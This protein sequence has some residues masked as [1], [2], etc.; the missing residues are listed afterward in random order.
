MSLYRKY[1]PQTF[2]EVVG[3]EHIV[4]T[5]QGAIASS[6]IG[7]AYIFAGPRGTGKTSIARIFAKAVNCLKVKDGEPCGQCDVCRQIAEGT[8]LDMIEID[9]ASNR[10]IDD[11]RDLK[12]KIIFS[13]NVGKYKVYIIDEAHMLSRD[14]FNALLKTLEEPPA[15]VIFVLATTESQKIPMTILSRCQRF[16]F[17]R[18]NS[19]EMIEAIKII[20]KAEKIKTTDAIISQIVSLGEGSFRDSLSCLDQ[21][22][23]FSGSGEI[24]DQ[25]LEDVLGVPKREVFL[26]FLEIISDRK[27]RESIAFVHKLSSRGIDWEAF[28][29][30]FIRF[31][32]QLTLYKI[33]STLAPDILIDE[34]MGKI[35]KKMNLTFLTEIAESFNEILK[36]SKYSFLPELYLEL[37]LMK[38]REEQ[39]DGTEKKEPLIIE[40]TV[41]PKIKEAVLEK[42]IERPDSDKLMGALFDGT[43]GTGPDASRRE[44]RDRPI[45]AGPDASIGAGKKEGGSWDKFINKLKE[46]KASLVIALQGCQH[47]E[48]GEDINIV[49]SNGFYFDRLMDRSNMDFLEKIAKEIFGQETRL[50]I[51]RGG[52]GGASKES[53]IVEE[54]L[55]VFGGEIID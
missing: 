4:K 24:D 37:Y 47:S 15:H 14:A 31:T 26:E 54:A 35:V 40:Q 38:M 46:D 32:R 33:D 18:I 25:L 55:N 45:G 17:R 8:F 30:N 21:V 44:D 22:Y 52:D 50:L 28:L 19:Q 48:A 39:K 11:I 27:V 41:E 51:T 12:E 6:Q 1:R 43:I 36:N 13:P 5:L 7:H 42:K 16:D 9:A 34:Q 2:D 3:Q 10:G 29:K 49:I 20:V 53:D 23:A